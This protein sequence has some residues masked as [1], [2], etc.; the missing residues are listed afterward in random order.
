MAYFHKIELSIY[1]TDPN[2][3]P[4]QEK[5]RISFLT[6]DFHFTLK[7][8]FFWLWVLIKNPF[9]TAYERECS[10]KERK[11]SDQSRL[12]FMVESF[13]RNNFKRYFCEGFE[14]TKRNDSFFQLKFL[15]VADMNE[16][17]ASVSAHFSSPSYRS[18][19][20]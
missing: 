18:Q 11:F 5:E 12:V 4:L 16:P 10:Q 1:L 3:K 20:H 19:F 2:L 6:L 17:I 9:Q 8:S 15:A 14:L 7:F 13:F